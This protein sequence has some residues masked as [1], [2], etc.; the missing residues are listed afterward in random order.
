MEYFGRS[1]PLKLILF[2]VTAWFTKIYL[3]KQ[4]FKKKNLVLPKLSSCNF[5]HFHFIIVHIFIYFYSRQRS[6]AIVFLP[7]L[8]NWI[9]SKPSVLVIFCFVLGW[10]FSPL[11]PSVFSDKEAKITIFIE[12]KQKQ[13]MVKILFIHCTSCIGSEWHI[14]DE[15][16][17]GLRC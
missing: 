10:L 1:C 13:T 15:N 4:K 12:C 11:H 3:S 14:I 17:F 9:S 8:V 6:V 7:N 2:K 16:I 5:Y